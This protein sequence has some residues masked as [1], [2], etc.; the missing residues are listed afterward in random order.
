MVGNII[1]SKTLGIILA[2]GK[3]SRLYPATQAVSKQLLPIYDKPLIYYPLSTLMLAGIR[4]ILVIVNPTEKDAFARLFKDAKVTM[5][6]DITITVQDKPNGLPEDFTIAAEVTD[7]KKYDNFV[8][9]LG[10]NIFHGATLTGSLKNAMNK[11]ESQGQSTIF[12]QHVKDPHRFGVVSLDKYSDKIV[13]I[14]EKP[15]TLDDRYDNLAITGLYFFDRDVIRIADSLVPSARG[16][17]EIIDII[18]T[19]RNMYSLSVEKMKRGISWFDTGTPDSLLDAAHYVKTIQNNQ[20]F[21]VG[22][23][24]EVAIKSA[25]VSDPDVLEYLKTVFKTEYGRLLREAFLHG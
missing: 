12:A 19:Y 21:L 25:W 14:V 6:V 2:A 18:N 10:D 20:G 24:H 4:D 22:S 1:M 7:Y 3:S 8:L 5:G 23:P 17:T 15:G 16:E 13:S 9:I 11:L